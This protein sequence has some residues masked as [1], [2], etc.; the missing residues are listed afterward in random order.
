MLIISLLRSMVN[1]VAS[2]HTLKAHGISGFYYPAFAF[3]LVLDTF[4]FALAISNQL[5]TSE[6]K[7]K[8]TW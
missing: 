1:L 3:F 6:K 4:Y 5:L 8:L 7:S 2:F